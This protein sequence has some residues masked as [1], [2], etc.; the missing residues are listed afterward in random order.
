MKIKKCN[1]ILSICNLLLFLNIC[2]VPIVINLFDLNIGALSALNDEINNLTNLL[3]TSFIIIIIFNLICIMK[4]RSYKKIILW[5]GITCI[6]FLIYLLDFNNIDIN[7][8]Y[9]VIGIIVPNIIAILNIV[10]IIKERKSKK[11]LI[12]YISIIVS[13][14]LVFVEM[15]YMFIWMAIA[16]VMQFIENGKAIYMEEGKATRVVNTI[17]FCTLFIITISTI[18]QYIITTTKVFS[19]DN[20]ITDKQDEFISLVETSIKS[21]NLNNDVLIEV[22]RNGKWGLV[23]QSGEEIIPCEYDNVLSNITTHSGKEYI[24][25]KNKYLIA[26]KENKYYIILTNGK[27]IAS[28]DRE[29]LPWKELINNNYDEKNILTLGMVFL[30]YVPNLENTDIVIESKILDMSDRYIDDNYYVYTYN[31][32]G[33][34]KMEARAVDYQKYN[35]QIKDIND[36][37]ILE[38]KDVSIEIDKYGDIR[39]NSYIHRWQYTIL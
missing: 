15:W 18:T 2:I 9:R 6:S 36:E 20:D 3:N 32:E 13:T 17:L 1:I 28:Y 31:L 26:V 5:Y 19:Y 24:I 11:M 22:C 38:D 29:N 30:S 14:I 16:I 12:L 4:N 23:N 37:I 21:N 33:G 8:I 34:Y 10:K 25:R 7:I 39:K 27:I 35:I